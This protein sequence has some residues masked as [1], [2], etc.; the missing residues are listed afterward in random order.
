MAVIEL[1]TFR[2]ADGVAEDAF[3]EVDDRVRARFLYQQPG[4]VRA[5][6]ARGSDGSWALL[7]VW[8]SEEAAESAA[9]AAGADPA[10]AELTAMVEDVEHRR[11][12]DLPG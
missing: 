2:L 9:S 1:T 7:V 6:T 8:G 5:T 12:E 4:I 11:W 3:L 10:W